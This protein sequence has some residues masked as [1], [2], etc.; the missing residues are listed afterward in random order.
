VVVNQRKLVWKYVLMGEERETRMCG[1]KAHQ[2][3]T[4]WFD[5]SLGK[6]SV[7]RC[8]K[9]L[10]IERRWYGVF[11]IGSNVFDEVCFPYPIF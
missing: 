5:E 6:I 10:L 3:G 4:I 11:N 8:V 1:C 7:S 2:N 9:K